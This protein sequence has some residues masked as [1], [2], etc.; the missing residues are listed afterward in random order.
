MNISY[1][2]GKVNLEHKDTGAFSTNIFKVP[3]PHQKYQ[4]LHF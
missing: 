1:K 2:Y 3:F 4:G